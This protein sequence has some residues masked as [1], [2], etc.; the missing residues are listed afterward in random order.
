V[1]HVQVACPEKQRPIFNADFIFSAAANVS[2]FDIIQSLQGTIP[3]ELSAISIPE[4]NDTVG[5]VRPLI[6]PSLSDQRSSC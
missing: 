1:G 6:Q 2:Y 5:E 4:Y 3:A